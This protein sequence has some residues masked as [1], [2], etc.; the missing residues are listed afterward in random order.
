[1]TE[2]AHTHTEPRRQSPHRSRQEELGQ[3]LIINPIPACPPT[4][5]RE[6]KA[7]SCSLRREELNPTVGSQLVTL[8]S[9]R[10]EPKT[11][12]FEIQ[13]GSSPKNP[14]TVR[15][16]L[17]GSL[18]THLH[19]DS[20]QRQRVWRHPDLIRLKFISTSWEEWTHWKRLMLGGIG[21]RRRRG[22]QRMRWLDGITDSMDASRGELRELVMYREAWHAAIHGV[23]KSRTRLSD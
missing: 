12:S 11:F 15:S 1:M 17:M 7:W 5:Q 6:L 20:T 14:Q 2:H 21:G 19:Q 16:L 4:N 23:A 10:Q 8:A 9:E 18:M 22:R 13:Q 3:N